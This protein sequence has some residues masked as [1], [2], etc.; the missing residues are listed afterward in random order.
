MSFYSIHQA[1]DAHLKTVAGLPPLQE[2]NVRVKIGSGTK[3]WCRSTLI[4]N[5]TSI[6]TVGPSGYSRLNGILQVDLYF[7][8]D[9]KYAQCYAMADL[10]IAKF[11]AGTQL[12]TI[13]IINSYPRAG[14]GG[15]PGYYTL[16]IIIEWENYE[17]RTL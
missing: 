16:P 2:E 8:S 10:V 6:S 4:N 9:S 12:G 3:P 13:R 17:Q 5:P 11:Q 15:A 1:L 7:P 14:F